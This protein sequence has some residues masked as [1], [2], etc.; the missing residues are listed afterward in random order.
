[1]AKRDYY[2][3][4]GVDK[5]VSEEEIKKAYRRLAMKYHPDKNPDNKKEAEEKFKE[6][7]EAYEVL[8]DQNKRAQYD[9]FGHEGMS[10]IFGRGGFT[11]S[12]FTHFGD[13]E[14]I[15]GDFFGGS[16]IGGLFEGLFGRGRARQRARGADLRYNLEIDLREAAFGCEKKIEVPRQEGCPTCKG[17]GARPGTSKKSCPSCRGSGQVRY[18]QGFFSI[19]RT[20]ESCRGEGQII[21]TP[22][23]DCRG[24]GLVQKTRTIEVKIPAGVETGSRLR[25]TGEGGAAPYGG[26]PGDLYVVIYVRPDE[27]FI[28]EEN[29]ILCEV[30]ISFPQAALGAE[31]EVPTLD[32]SKIKMKV[33]A[34]TQSHKIFRLRGKG[35]VNLHGHGRGDELV[36]IIIQTPTH[37]NQKERELLRQF[38]HLRG[39]KGRGVFGKVKDAFG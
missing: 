17:S 8:S 23:S 29:D 21:E 30:P 18:S 28:R 7:S 9:R 11:W 1:M 6:I 39:E 22:C 35:I 5:G 13:I 24:Q 25:I 33:P 34:G 15:F 37:L 26:S 12:D 3:V 32:G 10:D 38:E 19:A 14:D 2:E 31:I 4:L 20:C 36:K 16:S 27:R